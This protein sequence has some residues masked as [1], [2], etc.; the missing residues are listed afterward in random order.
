MSVVRWLF[1]WFTTIVT[2]LAMA[3]IITIFVFQPMQVLGSSMEPSLTHESKIFVSK[4]PYTLNEVPDYEEIVII[5]SR[6]K[7]KHTLMDDLRDSPL[8]SLFLDEEEKIYYVKRVIGRPGDVLEFKNNRI[9]R[10][11]V[12]LHEP[13]IKEEMKNVPDQIIKVPEGHVYVLGD[14]RNHS[15]D[16]R[17][18]GPIPLTHVIGVKMF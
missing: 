11:G 4:I 6:V 5:D 10:N 12:L 9:Y 8:Y 18:I 17:D 15:R 3:M 13:Y 7:R 14:N 1:S 2:G 16:S